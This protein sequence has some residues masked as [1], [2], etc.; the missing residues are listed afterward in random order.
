MADNF[1]VSYDKIDNFKNELS[2]FMTE[3]ES[4]K[5]FIDDIF[6]EGKICVFKSLHS[7]Y[8]IKENCKMTITITENF[9]N[10]NEFDTVYISKIKEICK[11]Y[12]IYVSAPYKSDFINSFKKNPYEFV[13]RLNGET[14]SGMSGTC[15]NITE[16]VTKF[17]QM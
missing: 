12:F 14:V 3:V 7:V 16:E 13:R 8:F 17:L 11:K 1:V 4:G 5:M 9:L 15:K 10:G 6:N 2:N